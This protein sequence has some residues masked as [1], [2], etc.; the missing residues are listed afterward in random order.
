MQKQ[1][2]MNV[3]KLSIICS[4]L[5][6]VALFYLMPFLVKEYTDFAFSIVTGILLIFVLALSILFSFSFAIY[7]LMH[8]Y[9][10]SFICFIIIL[11]FLW[12]AS[13]LVI[14]LYGHFN[15]LPLLV[16][17]LPLN[18]FIIFWITCIIF[19]SIKM[20]LFIK[21]CLTI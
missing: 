12:A 2:K 11:C 18:L 14:L 10:I 3:I 21:K 6:L 13:F 16:F 9:R 20:I 8:K 19:I 4:L 7:P 17:T 1:N 5:T 15:K